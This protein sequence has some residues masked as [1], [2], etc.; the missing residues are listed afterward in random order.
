MTAALSA[1]ALVAPAPTE[2]PS[3]YDRCDELDETRP[4]DIDECGRCDGTGMYVDVVD[5][6]SGYRLCS[7]C[8]GTG[9]RGVA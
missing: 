5:G 2:P 8:A 3:P 9:M 7:W 1:R 4:A 6:E